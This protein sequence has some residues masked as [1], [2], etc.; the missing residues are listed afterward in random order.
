VQWTKVETGQDLG[1]IALTWNAAKT[2]YE[3]VIPDNAGFRE[4]LAIDG[5]AMC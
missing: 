4:P 3:S 5:V 1:T 2:R